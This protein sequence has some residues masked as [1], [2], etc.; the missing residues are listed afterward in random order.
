MYAAIAFFSAGAVVFATSQNMSILILGRLL[1]GIGAGGLDVLPDVILAD[2]TSLKERPKYIGVVGIFLAVGMVLGPIIGAL[3]SQFLDWRWIGWINLPIIGVGFLLAVFFLHLKPI[4][5][6]FR[7]KL[8]LLDWAGMGLLTIGATAVSLP[9]SWSSSLYAWSSWQTL[10]PFV[11]G[12]F[13]LVIFGLHEKRTGT[14]MIPFRIF[15]NTTAVMSL[16]TS[17]LNGAIIYSLLQVSN[18]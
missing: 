13:V 16:I 15:S 9:L 14:A 10:V 18:S 1:Q 7:I 12:L 3:L 4:D 5:A 2:I 6:P 8:R 11:I 17:L